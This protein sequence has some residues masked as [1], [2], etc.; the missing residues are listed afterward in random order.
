MPCT[1]FRASSGSSPS[2]IISDM[3][4][5][6]DI[7]S[8]MPILAII[9]NCLRN[10]VERE[11]PLRKR[12]L[13]LLHL[14]LG[15]LLL[16]RRDLLDHAHQV[17]LAEDAPGHPLGNEVFELIDLLADADELDRHAGDALDGKRRAAAGVAVELGQD[18]GVEF[19]RV[20]ERLR[21]VR[22]LLADHRVDDEVDFVR[23]DELVDPLQLVHQLRDRSASRPAVSRMTVSQSV[24]LRLRDRVAADV[25][26][27]GLLAVDRHADLLAERLELFD[28]AG[29]LQVGGGEHRLAAAILERERELRGRGRLARTL[30]AA[31]H[32]HDRP[33]GA[34]RDLGIDRTH[35]LAEF[36]VNDL[37]DLFGRIDAREHVLA[38]RLGFDAGDEI[39]ED[40]EVDVGFEE[41]AAD[42]AQAFLD[43]LGSEPAATAELLER[44]GEAASNAFKHAS[45]LENSAAA[46]AAAFRYSKT[47]LRPLQ[48]DRKSATLSP[49][50]CGIRPRS[51]VCFTEGN[52]MRT[53]L[54]VFILVLLT[55]PIAL[56]DDWPQW[57]GPKR[58]GVW[59][60]TGIVESFPKDGPKKNWSTPLGMGYAGPA[61]AGGKV[62]VTDRQLAAGAK[63]PDGPFDRPK[64]NGNERVL[65]LD[66]KTG[67]KLWE[68]EYPAEYAISYA[69]GPRCT[70][71]VDGDRVYTLG[72]M[73]HLF[74][75]NVAD[76]KPIWSKDF[77][78][79]YESYLPVW[80]FAAHPLI[81]GD[82]LICLVGGSNNRLVVAFDK[83]N[84]KEL[85]S[86]E[87]CGGDFGYCPPMIYEFGGKRQ[88][89]IWHSRGVLGLEPDSGKRIWRV[90]FDAKAAL[91]APTPR[92]VGTDRLFITSFYNGSMLLK[93]GADKAEVV[94]KS[95]AKGEMPTQ[96]SDLSSIIPTPVI[97]GDHV[98]G[99]CSYGQLR[100]IEVDTGKRV[101]ETMNATRGALTPPKVAANDEPEP[102]NVGA[103]RSSS[104]TTIGTFSSTSR[105]ISSSRN[106]RR[107]ATRS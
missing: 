66:E 5:I 107:R 73:G 62:F 40:V 14:L 81:D 36:F 21:D 71:T 100:C 106:C 69:G 77:I 39:V 38:E 67:K 90:D 99:V 30:Q 83:K 35:Q 84:G 12:L 56:A 72:A 11:V 19:E 97:D 68:H 95:K 17:A 65:C 88:L 98:Y 28:G 32:E 42:F 89:I 46:S 24:L 25:D 23:L 20:V 44:F 93:V 9:W 34:L 59:R 75:L 8:F 96:T 103:T 104:S 50:S 13:L 101:W 3:P 70:P 105:A 64:V 60:E 29:A 18:A 94:W 33:V 87:S 85:W 78:K 86:A 41:G 22:G 7:M 79:D 80:G 2:G 1:R 58:D 45:C 43:V 15:N 55:S 76:G 16:D 51:D 91:T 47:T 61:V 102:A 37:D 92:K 54:I 48:P 52:R 26:R 74:C 53:Q 31:Q 6:R 10:I 4:G 57:L 49:V 82:K 63:N 27:V